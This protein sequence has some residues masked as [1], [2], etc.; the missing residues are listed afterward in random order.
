MA[1]CLTPP[2]GRR[3]LFW[4]TQPDAQGT[5]AVCQNACGVPGFEYTG[6]AAARSI[7]TEDWVRGLIINMIMTDGREADNACGWFP[8]AQGGHWSESYMS[9][10]A[11]VGTLMRSVSPQ[12]TILQTTALLRA[13][14]VATLER[15]VTRGVALSVAVEVN[16]KGDGR[17]EMDIEVHGL[18][19]NIA[20]VGLSGERLS[21][22]W[23]WN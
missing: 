22:G 7:S 10:P 5:D 23:V 14:A 18:S 17:F 4:A 21:N 11:V 6:N 15:L 16:Y 20:R 2:Q 1:T 9:G 19:N 8:G 12:K 3:T 13:Y